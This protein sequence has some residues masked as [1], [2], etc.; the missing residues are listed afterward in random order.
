MVPKK[1]L[2]QCHFSQVTMASTHA[3]YY[4]AKSGVARKIL[5]DLNEPARPLATC[6]SIELISVNISGRRLT[7]ARDATPSIN[8]GCEGVRKIFPIGSRW[9]ACRCD[10]MPR[11]VPPNTG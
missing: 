1:G 4:I 5:G 11:C 9:K 8:K 3:R 7:A 2:V 6:I 10:H